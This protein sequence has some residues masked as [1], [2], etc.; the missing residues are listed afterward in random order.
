M[1]AWPFDTRGPRTIHAFGDP[2]AMYNKILL[3]PMKARRGGPKVHKIHFEMQK[4][5][6]LIQVPMHRPGGHGDHQDETAPK[7]EDLEH[8]VQQKVFECTSQ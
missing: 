5:R 7:D 8:D 2:L 6:R 1:A 4:A 3:K